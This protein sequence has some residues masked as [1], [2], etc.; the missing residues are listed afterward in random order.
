MNFV[1]AERIAQALHRA[2]PFFSFVIGLGIAAVLFHR[3]YDTINT[4]ALP[5]KDVVDRV[6]RVDGKC[7]RYRV[8]DSNCENSS[9]S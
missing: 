1:R 8:E 7:Y 4:V 6:V 2:A 9:V 5:V 3:N